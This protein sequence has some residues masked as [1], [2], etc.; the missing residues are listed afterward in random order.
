M[1]ALLVTCS[2]AK[3]KIQKLRLVIEGERTLVFF[4]AR[5]QLLSF[6]RRLA[7]PHDLNAWSTEENGAG[8]SNM[9]IRDCAIIIRKG[10]S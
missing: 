8:Q 4:Y 6:V 9:H 7:T 10:G 1:F 2:A 3:I 5:L